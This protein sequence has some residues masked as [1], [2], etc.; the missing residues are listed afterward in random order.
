MSTELDKTASQ[1]ISWL[2]IRQHLID[3]EK[4]ESEASDVDNKI[5]ELIEQSPNY[6]KE[7]KK[8]YDDEQN[9]NK[10]RDDLLNQKFFEKMEKYF[11]NKSKDISTDKIRNKKG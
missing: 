9:K 3:K 4:V 5:K 7:I 1:N 10:L 2:L 6:K 11:I 8:F